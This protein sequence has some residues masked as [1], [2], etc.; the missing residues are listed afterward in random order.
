MVDTSKN[1]AEIDGLRS[2]GTQIFDNDADDSI[3]TPNAIGLAGGHPMF[4]SGGR[5]FNCACGVY[6]GVPPTII[7]RRCGARCGGL[8]AGGR[9]DG[10]PVVIDSGGNEGTPNVLNASG[11]TAPGCGQGCGC[12][13]IIER[14]NDF[15]TPTI[16]R[17]K[18]ASQHSG[19]LGGC[20]APVVLNSSASGQ[21]NKNER[22]SSTAVDER[23]RS[24]PPVS[25][26]R[27]HGQ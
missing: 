12:P 5:H 9:A 11:S 18:C 3:P 13:I 10:H 26:Q 24:N 27:N 6:G 15:G 1:Y 16:S 7:H 21:N 25:I 19:G 17:G 8:G 23:M 14:N 2:C 20:R 4:A 22:V